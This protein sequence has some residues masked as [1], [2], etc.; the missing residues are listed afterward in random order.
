[1]RSALLA[2][3]LWTRGLGRATPFRRGV[4]HGSRAISVSPEMTLKILH[5]PARGDSGPSIPPSL[6]N[7]AVAHSLHPSSPTLLPVY[8]SRDRSSTTEVYVRCN[9]SVVSWSASIVKARPFHT[10]DLFFQQQHS[11]ITA[12]CCVP[13]SYVK[14]S[15]ER[16]LS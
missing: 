10:H 6:T 3:L 1:M 2:T 5:I 12:T 15:L 14:K 8:R 9:L 13:G 7:T 4:L 16:P 11:L